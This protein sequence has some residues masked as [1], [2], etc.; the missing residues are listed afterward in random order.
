MKATDR[1]D[2]IVQCLRESGSM[3]ED[4]ARRF[5]AEHDAHLRAEV[6]AADGQ[7]YDGELAMLHG[8][9]ATLAAVVEHGDL[10]D[11]RKLLAEHRADDAEA[12]TGV[13]AA[14]NFFQPG[15][16]YTDDDHATDWRFRCDSITTH[17]EDG[18]RTALGWR[19]FRGQWEPCAYGED[20]WEIHQDV[21]TWFFATEGGA[22]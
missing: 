3:Y 22:R 18:E 4:D 11:V 20:D 10:G 7:A 8:L 15:H 12:R 16:T 21:G 6:L 13:T 17:P 1:A 5:L 2:Y 9:I 19:Y 14:P